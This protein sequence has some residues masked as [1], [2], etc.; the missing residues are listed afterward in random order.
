MLVHPND[1]DWT[2]QQL[3]EKSLKANYQKNTW[4]HFHTN[5]HVAAFMLLTTGDGA[6]EA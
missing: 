5:V 4:F 6:K 1:I 3:L 2:H